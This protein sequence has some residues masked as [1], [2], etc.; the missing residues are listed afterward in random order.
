MRRVLLACGLLLAVVLS[1]CTSINPIVVAILA[2]D[3]SAE[4]QQPLDLEALTERIEQTCDGCSIKVYD[5]GSDAETQS[6]QLDKALVAS[7]D[8]VILDPVDPELAESLVRRA[9]EVPVLALGTLVQGA[10]WFVGLDQ[11]ASTADGAGSDLEA[12]REVILRHRHSFIFVPATQ[13]SVQAADVAVGELVEQPV[14]RSVEHGGVPSWL[15]EP[16]EVT[17]NDLTSVVVATGAMTLDDLCAGETAQ[18]CIKL[19]LV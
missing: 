18:R 7:A 17:V 12:A 10:D 4:L 3:Q 13:I 5:A 19:G 1:G 16:A 9:D 11:P 14:S 2:A 6:E 8:I 15:F